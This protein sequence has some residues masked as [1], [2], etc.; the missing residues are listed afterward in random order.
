MLTEV[1]LCSI[2]E[3]RPPTCSGYRCAW[4]DGAGPIE[5]Q[6]DKIHCLVDLAAN[7]S[8]IHYSGPFDLKGALGTLRRLRRLEGIAFCHPNGN[9]KLLYPDAWKLLAVVSVLGLD[10][11]AAAD[12]F[13]AGVSEEI[14]EQLNEAAR[15]VGSTVL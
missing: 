2:Y 10:A 13:E 1:G 14:L 3:E 15:Y 6:P 4:L 8:R 12:A 11:K 5:A 7:C 9:Y